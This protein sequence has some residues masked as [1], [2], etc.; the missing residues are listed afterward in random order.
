VLEEAHALH[1]GM[2]RL[3]EV[4]SDQAERMLRDVQAAHRRMQADLRVSPLEPA[5]PGRAR[6][7]VERDPAEPRAAELS[8]SERIIAAAEAARSESERRP[9]RRDAPEH[10]PPREREVP[11][12]GREAPSRARGANPFDDLDVPSWVARDR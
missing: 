12:R 6:T 10:E 8:E 1:S 4:L 11:S 5:P 9:R 2:R 3:G 7:S